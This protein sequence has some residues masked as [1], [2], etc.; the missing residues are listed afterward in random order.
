M[1]AQVI[2]RIRFC[3]TRCC[4]FL[5]LADEEEWYGTLSCQPEGN[6]SNT[7][8]IF[9][10]W[11]AESGHSVFR[12]SSPVCRGSWKSKGGGKQSIHHTASPPPKKKAE[13][14]LETTTAV[15]ISSV[16]TKQWQN[17]APVETFRRH[18]SLH[19]M[20]KFATC[21]QSE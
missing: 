2:T 21:H 9:T 20:T 18:L 5:G 16:I 13:L 3:Q 17:G 15:N 4:T 8:Q 12:C 19:R 7:A 1:Q 14:L 11:F 6:R 10:E